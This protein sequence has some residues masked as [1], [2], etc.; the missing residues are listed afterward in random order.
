MKIL[1]L[2]AMFMTAPLCALVAN[3]LPEKDHDVVL[4]A[5]LIQDHLR[6]TNGREINLEEIL[7]ADTLN[8]ISNHFE[9][10]ACTFKGGHISVYYTFSESRD[11]KEIELLDR[12]K[13]RAKYFRWTEKKLKN[14]YDGEIR[15]DYG[16]RFYRVMKLI[17]NTSK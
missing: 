12:E 14:E 7:R 2:L 17:L 4:L 3:H 6:K 1:I 5:I 13:E 16:E 15:L 10:V 8:R 9:K 11:V